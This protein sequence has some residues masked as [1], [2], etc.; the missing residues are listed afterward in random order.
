[1]RKQTITAERLIEAI[2][3]RNSGKPYP[4]VLAA[5]GLTPDQFSRAV[6]NL[7]LLITSAEGGTLQTLEEILADDNRQT[8]LFRMGEQ[9]L[10][11]QYDSVRNKTQ[12]KLCERTLA[13]PENV[14]L[15]AYHALTFNNP[16]LKSA[17]REEV[18]QGIK[19]LPINLQDYL[20]SIGLS[21]VMVHGF[22]KGERDSPLAVLEAFDR[23]YQRK[24]GDKSLFDLTKEQHLHE[25]GDT[26]KAP[27]SYWSGNPANVQKAIYHMLTENNP[28]LASTNRKESIQGIKKLPT[29]LQD[30]L[31]SIGLSGLMRGGFEEGERGSPL[32]VLKAFDRAYQRKTGHKSLFDKRHKDYLE[33]A[34]RNILVRQTNFAE[35]SIGTTSTSL[36]S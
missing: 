3:D 26:F 9:F 31:Y 22:E 15:L 25:W 2:L 29:N 19:T 36:K 18:I 24:T 33:S 34:G 32:A 8:E 11:Q 13:H 30:Y 28:Q 21:G 17:K 6:Q 5:S 35:S 7:H 16:Q 14:E 10:Q 20:Y 12:K 4:E 27:Q 23:A 1:M